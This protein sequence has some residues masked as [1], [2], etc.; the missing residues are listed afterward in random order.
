M[1]RFETRTSIKLNLLAS[2]AG[3]WRAMRIAVCDNTFEQHLT[4]ELSY[5]KQ[6]RFTKIKTLEKAG[7]LGLSKYVQK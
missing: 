6:W 3:E 7:I 5:I 1:L 2:V 4:S